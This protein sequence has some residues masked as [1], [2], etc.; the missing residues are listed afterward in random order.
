M[1]FRSADD[2]LFETGEWLASEAWFPATA[3][4][5][6]VTARVVTS[7]PDEDLEQIEFVALQAVSSARHSIRLATPYF[8]PPPPLVLALGLA[9]ALK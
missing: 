7:G 8:L 2:W 6:T 4:A 5:G 9:W 1:L 3:E